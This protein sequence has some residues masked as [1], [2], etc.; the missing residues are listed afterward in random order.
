M[1][2]ILSYIEDLNISKDVKVYLY[3]ESLGTGIALSFLEAHP[4]AAYPRGIVR[5]MLLLAPFTSLPEASL[6]HP[7]GA[8]FRIFPIVKDLM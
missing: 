3:A 4:E 8:P 7:V 2:A 1:H 6:A 5:G